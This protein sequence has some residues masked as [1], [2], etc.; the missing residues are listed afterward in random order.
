[1][2]QQSGPSAHW[3]LSAMKYPL[4]SKVVPQYLSIP[5]SSVITEQVFSVVVKN[6]QTGALLLEKGCSKEASV[7]K[8]KCLTWLVPNEN[9]WASILYPLCFKF[10]KII[11]IIS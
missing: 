7:Y 5:A 2:P 8:K 9:I 3:K 10:Y 6:I 11:L 4:L 1:M